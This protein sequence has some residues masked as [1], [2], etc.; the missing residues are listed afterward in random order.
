MKDL[1]GNNGYLC[2][3]WCRIYVIVT[4]NKKDTKK[5]LKGFATAQ[6]SHPRF[7]LKLVC[8]RWSPRTEKSEFKQK[9]FF[10]MKTYA[11][12]ISNLS[13]KAKEFKTAYDKECE[14]LVK[15]LNLWPC[16]QV[17]RNWPSGLFSRNKIRKKLI[18]IE[19][20]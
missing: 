3:K 13:P 19:N 11:Q 8:T 17:E 10:L 20:E 18:L 12:V 14:Y 7:Y 1:I 9:S 4:L 5:W 15:F 16:V 6:G 2:R